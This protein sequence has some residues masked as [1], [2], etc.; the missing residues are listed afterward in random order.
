MA[1]VENSELLVV[2]GFDKVLYFVYVQ[3]VTSCNLMLLKMA[4]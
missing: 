4:D 3:L 1:T 2:S